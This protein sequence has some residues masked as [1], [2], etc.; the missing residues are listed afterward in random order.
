MRSDWARVCVR[1]REGAALTRHPRCQRPLA[2]R[3]HKRRLSDGP[4]CPEEAPHPALGQASPRNL[5]VVC[6]PMPW[7]RASRVHA[8]SALPL[9]EAFLLCPKGLAAARVSRGVCHGGGSFLGV[10]ERT[11]CCPFCKYSE[12]SAVGENV[13]SAAPGTRLR[14]R[15]RCSCLLYTSPS[16]RDRTRSRMPSSA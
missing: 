4:L 11:K 9:G 3:W 10:S 13:P 8:C 5:T 14:L 6:W 7:L 12:S 16:P 1:A 2:W 15:A